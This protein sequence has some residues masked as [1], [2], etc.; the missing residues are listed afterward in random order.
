VFFF[1]ASAGPSFAGLK[2]EDVIKT[3]LV[4]RLTLIR[5]GRCHVDDDE[6][7]ML[8]VGGGEYSALNVF[9]QVGLTV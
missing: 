8:F 6:G 4:T 9:A 3:A 2:I 5:D 1:P 7:K